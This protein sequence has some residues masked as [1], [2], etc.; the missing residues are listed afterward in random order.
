MRNAENVTVGGDAIGCSLPRVEDLPLLI[1]KATF[2]DDLPVTDLLEVSFV[3]SSVAHGRL[4]SVDTNSASS[5]PGVQAVFSA[6]DLDLPPIVSPNENPNVDPPP[7][8]LLA[9]D[10]VRY[11][12][13][14]IAVAVARN[15]YEAEDACEPLVV[16]Y[17]LTVR[18]CP[19]VPIPKV[20]SAVSLAPMMNLQQTGS[21]G[22][23]E[24]NLE[25]AGA[26]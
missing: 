21:C 3:R 23:A 17:R 4:L 13:E 12:G 15:R 22:Q 14:P 24:W 1:G 25:P 2:V 26:T 8:P 10:K 18:L 5:L 11:A 9:T 19:T 6:S 16:L 20:E 7:Q